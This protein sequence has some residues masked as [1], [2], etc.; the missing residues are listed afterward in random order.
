[1]SVRLLIVDDQ[2]V[3]RSNLR[4]QFS[5]LGCEV[6]EAANALEGLELFQTFQPQVVTLDI[7]MPDVDGFTALDLLRKIHQASDN[8]A[9]I[10]ISNKL[11]R[12]DEF[13][14]EGAIEFVAKPFETFENL[15]RKV[16]PLI[17][18]LDHA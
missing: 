3:I 13:L 4:L 2:A 9:V 16:H 7:V 6:A 1:M 15:T 12:R 5:R 8:T 17:Q 11:D 14:R 10:V 18:V